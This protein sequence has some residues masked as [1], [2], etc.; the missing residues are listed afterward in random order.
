MPAF[1][2]NS[3]RA[4]AFGAGAKDTKTC[5]RDMDDI[6]LAVDRG[7]KNV[8]TVP[9]PASLADDRKKG[10]VFPGSDISASLRAVSIKVEQAIDRAA[11]RMDQSVIRALGEAGSPAHGARRGAIKPSPRRPGA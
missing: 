10:T 11:L 1:L 2:E 9:S 8:Q 6:L 3:L 5:K 4:G 7:K